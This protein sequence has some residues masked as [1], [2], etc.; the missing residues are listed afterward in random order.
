MGMKEGVDEMNWLLS[1]NDVKW[2]KGMSE[3]TGNSSEMPAIN[4]E[5]SSLI[6]R[7]LTYIGMS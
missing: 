2:M 6:D 7:K 3:I 1:P 5:F 4:N